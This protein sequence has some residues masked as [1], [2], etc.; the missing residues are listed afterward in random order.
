MFLFS[1]DVHSHLCMFVKKYF[2]LV[3]ISLFFSVNIYVYVG[4]RGMNKNMSLSI[5][6]YLCVCAYLS[7]ALGQLGGCLLPLCLL[8]SSLLI[9]K[10]QC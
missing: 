1:Y 3:S 2:A 8:R 4:Q 5:N 7:G 9:K 6:G 10:R